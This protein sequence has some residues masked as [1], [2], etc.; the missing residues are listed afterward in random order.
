MNGKELIDYL[1]NNDSKRIT[2]MEV[3]ELIRDSLKEIVK[4]EGIYD[5]ILR[6]AIDDQTDIQRIVAK[7]PKTPMVT[8]FTLSRSEDVYVREAIAINPSTPEIALK[9]LAK[10]EEGIV[11]K[12]LAANPNTP[13]EILDDLSKGRTDMG[14]LEN[15]AENP[16]TKESTLLSLAEEKLPFLNEKIIKNPH[17]PLYARDRLEKEL[18]IKDKISEIQEESKDTA[19]KNEESWNRWDENKTPVVSAADRLKLL[20]NHNSLNNE[21]PGMFDDIIEDPLANNKDSDEI[22]HDDDLDILE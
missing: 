17:F 10:S 21:L 11:K 3:Y 13:E 18:G 19:N 4:G 8:L 20:I 22:D 16:N 5:E 15:I 2:G 6:K 9:E 7:N 12:A 14:I 1:Y